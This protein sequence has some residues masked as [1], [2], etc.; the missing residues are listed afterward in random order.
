MDLTTTYLGLRLASPVMPGASPI[1]KSL[2]GVK[3][4]EDA[5]AAAIV[6][7]SLFEE[8]INLRSPATA[9]GSKPPRSWS[10]TR[11]GSL[12]GVLRSRPDCGDCREFCFA[13]APASGTST[14]GSQE[15]Q[16]ATRLPN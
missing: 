1:T 16:R 5:G 9:A 11:S 6:L 8:Q 13:C 14:P 15:A 3:Q 2:D 4:L 7:H 12:G 10:A